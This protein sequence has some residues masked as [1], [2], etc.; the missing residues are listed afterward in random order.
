MYPGW[1]QGRKG[2]CWQ[3]GGRAAGSSACTRQAPPPPPTP[4]TP[5]AGGAASPGW[6]PKP[7]LRQHLG[8]TP[9]GECSLHHATSG[10]TLPMTEGTST[11]MSRLTSRATMSMDRSKSAAGTGPVTSELQPGYGGQSVKS[12]RIAARAAQIGAGSAAAALRCSGAQA[13]RGPR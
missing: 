11:E 10:L 13:G 8:V 12:C 6:G 3:D 7:Q 2:G 9:W 4:P 1:L 5:P